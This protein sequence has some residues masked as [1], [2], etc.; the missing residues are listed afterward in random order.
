MIFILLLYKNLI[1]GNIFIYA[2]DFIKLNKNNITSMVYSGTNKSYTTLN[3]TNRKYE[4]ETEI[5]KYIGYII[6]NDEDNEDIYNIEEQIKGFF[7]KDYNIVC[8]DESY[9]L[10][11]YT[12]LI[13][14]SK[15]ESLIYKLKL[16]EYFKIYNKL[17][18]ELKDKIY[19][20]LLKKYYKMNTTKNL[21]NILFKK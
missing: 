4:Y 9:I 13:E 21:L 18:I 20:K 10:T 19:L 15:K 7:D 5:M 1:T 12:T 6:F 3:N 8:L 2:N 16:I 14:Y 11:N 17:T